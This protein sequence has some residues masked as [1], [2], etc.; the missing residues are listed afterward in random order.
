MDPPRR[1]RN[2]GHMSNGP[3]DDHRDDDYRTVRVGA[4]E[5]ETLTTPS[6]SEDRGVALDPALLDRLRLPYRDAG[7]GPSWV[8]RDGNLQMTLPPDPA[9]DDSDQPAPPSGS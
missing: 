1:R 6:E 3:Q 8:R 7:T 4:A 5:T 2:D 9:V